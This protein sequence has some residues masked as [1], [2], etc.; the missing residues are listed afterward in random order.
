[1]V[2][3]LNRVL[4]KYGIT[5]DEQIRYFLSVC[6]HESRL[7]LTEAGWLSDSYVKDYCERYEPEQ[8]QVKILVIQ[9]M[10]M[11]ISIEVLA[12]FN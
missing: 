5:T 12:L 1:M 6:L 11:V 2:N 7:A 10:E 8:L 9:R 3:E 4:I